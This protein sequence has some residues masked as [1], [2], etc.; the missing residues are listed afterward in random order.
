MP[1]SGRRSRLRRW[2]P[3]RGALGASPAHCRVQLGPGV[4]PAEAVVPH[5]MLV[6]MLDRETL[7]ALAIK[8]LHLLGPVG[9][10]PLA[11]RL[12]EP[13]VQEPGLALLLMSSVSSA[14]TSA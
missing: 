13:A 11:R 5:Q 9:R 8:P 3:L 2:A 6:E 1:G 12:A 4:A 7:I 14:G 10:D